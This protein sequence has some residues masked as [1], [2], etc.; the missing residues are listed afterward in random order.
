[1]A[2]L[3][4]DNVAM[5]LR[6]NVDKLLRDNMDTLLRDNGNGHGYWA[7]NYYGW[8]FVDKDKGVKEW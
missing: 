3:L 5:L 6:D 8:K 4:R 7:D 2:T 1:V